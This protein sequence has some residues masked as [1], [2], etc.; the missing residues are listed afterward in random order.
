MRHHPKP[1]R[2]VVDYPPPWG[3][4]RRALPKGGELKVEGQGETWARLK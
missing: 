1:R 3:A 4:L 2:P